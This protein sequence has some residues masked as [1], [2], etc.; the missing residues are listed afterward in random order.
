M[1]REGVF[2][3][4]TDLSPLVWYLL[5]IMQC[6]Q[7]KHG[8]NFQ[9]SQPEVQTINQFFSNIDVSL[10]NINVFDIDILLLE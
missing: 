6:N 8:V 5:L 4:E 1:G 7:E 9:S 2:F 3:L 10:I